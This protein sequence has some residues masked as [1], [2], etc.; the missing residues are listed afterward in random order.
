MHDAAGTEGRDPVTDLETVRKEV[1]LYSKELAKRSW[2]ILAN[3]IDLEGAEENV[4]RLKD[5]FKRVR[6]LPISAE[7]GLGMDKLRAYLEK[8]IGQAYDK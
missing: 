8:Q 5:R 2:A 3:K 1:S 4:T 7:T 6:I